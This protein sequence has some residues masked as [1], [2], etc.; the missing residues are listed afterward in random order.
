MTVSVILPVAILCVNSPD[1]EDG[2]HVASATPDNQRGFVK[3]SLSALQKARLGRGNTA[4]RL[5]AKALLL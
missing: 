3:A 2:R 5:R 1:G 4:K